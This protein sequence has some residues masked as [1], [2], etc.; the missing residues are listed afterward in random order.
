MSCLFPL[1]RISKPWVPPRPEYQRR[2]YRGALII[3]R[4]EYLQLYKQYPLVEKYAVQIPCGQC[5]ECRL[6]SARQWALR[7]SFERDAHPTTSWFITLTYDDIHVPVM[8]TL[9]Q[10]T[11]EITQMLNL[12]KKDLQ[13]FHK[14]W[15]ARGAEFRFLA[16]GEY[17]DQTNR[18]HY[19]GC[20][21]GCD[22]TDLK[23]WSTGTS[24]TFFTSA[25]LDSVWQ[26]GRCIIAPLFDEAISYVSRYSM[27]KVKGK[28]ARDYLDI[29]D[30]IDVDPLPAEFMLSSRRPSLGK[31]FM[32]SDYDGS[33][34]YRGH[35]SRVAY[36][37]YLLKKDDPE[38][39]Q[40]VKL[41]RSR[42]HY[43]SEQLSNK[44]DFEVS[45]QL[46]KAADHAQRFK[47][48]RRFRN[49]V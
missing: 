25:F 17:G 7:C 31:F 45:D 26:H 38:A 27:K 29:C 9:N 43:I 10:E 12:R 40:A 36:F 2:I 47:A 15:R 46:S 42:R 14:R 8:E 6:D 37:D 11:G 34:P 19:H 13:D 48:S 16:V 22:F 32:P 21:F 20:Y 23:V 24:Q 28:P 49:G 3:K 41:R 1:Y 4:P 5:L 33:I 30:E 35:F 44:S 18:P 39:F